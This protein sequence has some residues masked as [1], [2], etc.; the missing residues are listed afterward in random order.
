MV[1]GGYN[2]KDYV[3]NSAEFLDLGKSLDQIPFGNLKWRNLPEMKFP[4]SNSLM[5]INDKYV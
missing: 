3:L 1:A 5:L 2:S 4:R